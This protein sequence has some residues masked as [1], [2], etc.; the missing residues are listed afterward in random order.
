MRKKIL[1]YLSF[2]IIIVLSAFIW[3]Y[4]NLPYENTSIIGE[5]SKNKFNQNN[6]LIRYLVFIFIP[7]FI[8]LIY[9]L[10]T[11]K[12]FIKN[13]LE[14]LNQENNFNSTYNSN[15]VFIFFIF[16]IFL[17][18]EFFSINFP[19][20]KVDSF[21]EGQQ[22]S[23]AFKY[24]LDNKLW[25]GSYVTVGI[26]Y[27]LISS[28]F[29]WNF[30]DNISIG[31][32]RFFILFL[33]F[34]LKILLVTF[35][36]QITKSTN[37]KGILEVIY[38]IIISFIS[39]NLVN[40][41]FEGGLLI[42]REIPVL[43][44]IIIF[45]QYFLSKSSS[46]YFVFYLGPISCLS[47]FY[48]LDRG[49]VANIFIFIFII[50]LIL[51]KNFKILSLSIVSIILSWAF[52]LYYLGNELEYFVQNT[53][54]TLNEIKQIGGIIHPI[55]FSGEQNSARSFKSL[56]L[57]SLALI[58]SIDLMCRKKT[59]FTNKFTITLFLISILCFLTYGY[60]IGRADGPHIRSTFG[61]IIIFYSVFIIY[62]TFKFFE[63]KNFLQKINKFSFLVSSL[64]IF[65]LFSQN[66]K[67]NNIFSFNSRLDNYI[68][69]KD[70]LFLKDNEKSFVKNAKN[71]LDKYECIQLFTNDVTMLY[72][73]RKP[74][75]TKFY[76][77][78]TIGSEKNQNF[79]INELKVVN[80]IL[81]DDDTS[82]FSPYHKLPLVRQYIKEN[83]SILYKEDKWTILE[84]K[85]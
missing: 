21:H 27:E 33:I 39:V 74:N 40:Y 38:F 18:L 75:C 49:L 44:T 43:L 64:L 17:F 15:L 71:I 58:I 54:S 26:I 34:V 8:M 60:A 31:S 16:L 1:F 9:L 66:I 69:Y 45:F 51:N 77:P 57:I 30:F 81:T 13:F 12:A 61:Y 79:L 82:E 7:I 72:L 68:N 36:Y 11:N 10:S 22:M 4:I 62:L 84:I 42:Y 76:F 2:V 6:D 28:D 55:P 24:G 53:L 50:N 29:I 5:Y 70:Q 78:I 47:I 25:S 48:S 3:P 56:F 63:K 41:L 80:I 20:H 73:L 23:G 52:S 19:L 65:I 46:K 67:F 85:K 32:V 59:T 35:S 83:Y 37:L 14:K